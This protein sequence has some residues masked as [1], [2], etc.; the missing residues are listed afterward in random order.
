MSGQAET[1]IVT[2]APRYISGSA[3]AGYLGFVLVASLVVGWYAARPRQFTEVSLLTVFVG[4]L[5]YAAT[6]G[7]AR[8]AYLNAVVKQRSP[9]LYSRVIAGLAAER[10]ARES[11]MRAEAEARRIAFEN[12]PAEVAKRQAAAY[13][14]SLRSGALQPVS[15]N[16]LVLA[17][18]ETVYWSEPATLVVHA[19]K[20]EYVGGYGGMSVRVMRGVSLR[21]GTFRGHPVKQDVRVKEDS[22]TL[23]I[24]DKRLVFIG[25][26]E[27]K[28]I[29]LAKM[30]SMR[31]YSDGIE[32]LPANKKAIGFE[33]GNAHAGIVLERVINRD[34]AAHAASA[35][36]AALPAAPMT[37]AVQPSDVASPSGATVKSNR[38]ILHAVAA[39][40]HDHV[41]IIEAEYDALGDAQPKVVAG[42]SSVQYMQWTQTKIDQVRAFMEKAA[43]LLVAD[44]QGPLSAADDAQARIATARWLHAC[45]D[46]CYAMIAWEKDVRSAPCPPKLADAHRLL[47]DLTKDVFDEIETLPKR[48]E[49]LA[50]QGASG[51]VNLTSTFSSDR[52]MAFSK[53]VQAAGHA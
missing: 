53:A 52:I 7:L 49:D 14:E 9:D 39:Q 44:L 29:P 27:S 43:Q 38:E 16:G 10:E 22:G 21:S 47:F 45:D 33:T 8:K 28:E 42:M 36:S 19:T 24:T 23:N 46:V 1:A 18:G 30:S 35:P 5:L 11:K 31:A 37:S 6:N 41:E 20:T 13:E 32:V 25:A 34:V 50:S 2:K 48:I 40:M 15:V 17:A 3:A 26:S 4:L 51:E 12:S